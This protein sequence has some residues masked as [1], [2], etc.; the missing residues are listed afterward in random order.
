MGFEEQLRNIKDEAFKRASNAEVKRIER[1]SEETLRKQVL[2]V[3]F[4]EERERVITRLDELNLKLRFNQTQAAA[5]ELLSLSKEDVKP[6]DYENYDEPFGDFWWVYN[7][8]PSSSLKSIPKQGRRSLKIDVMLSGYYPDS[9]RSRHYDFY[10]EAYVGY[11]DTPTQA[12]PHFMRVNGPGI[13][14]A[15]E[16]QYIR[17]L[18]E[19]TEE[20]VDEFVLGSIRRLNARITSG[21]PGIRSGEGGDGREKKGPSSRIYRN[22]AEARY[23][24][25]LRLSPD[26]FDGLSQEQKERLLRRTYQTVSQITHPDA[27]GNNEA[28][29]KV[30]EAYE[31]FK[32]RFG[33]K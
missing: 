27:G 30:N 5:A 23:F 15:N 17:P 7:P 33:I 8:S 20:Q 6:L 19:W 11:V 29:K 14:A 1:E 21:F 3:R 22:E 12:N 4:Q 28:F 24:N 9:N 25:A 2:E 13:S 32:G 18:E 10:L 16:Y 26:A 31:F